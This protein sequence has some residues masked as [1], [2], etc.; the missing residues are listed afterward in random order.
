MQDLAKESE[1]KLLARKPGQIP[2]WV[3]SLCLEEPSGNEF[4]LF[5]F[6]F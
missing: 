1:G 3:I 2:S 6:L 5:H 4:A